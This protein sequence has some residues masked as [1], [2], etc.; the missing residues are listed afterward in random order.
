[1]MAD[2][3]RAGNFSSSNI[4]RLCTDGSRPMTPEEKQEFV[5]A[6]GDKRKKNTWDYGAS[7]YSY[8]KE[9]KREI[10][11][12]RQVDNESKANASDWGNM[13]EAI[14]HE[15]L[16]ISYQ[17]VNNDRYKHPDLPWTGAPDEIAGELLVGDI[18]S[19]FTLTSFLDVYEVLSYEDMA[20]ALKNVKPEWYWQLIS[21]SILTE[22]PWCELILFMP[23]KSMIKELIFEHSE[24]SGYWFHNKSEKSLPWTAEDSDIPALSRIPFIAPN[25]DIE[26]LT[27][28]V[29]AATKLLKEQ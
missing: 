23:K 8:V 11:A 18:K 3:D 5:D 15:M 10:L 6:G 4:Y 12:G 14:V 25:E 28:R 29:R 27:D 22:R 13:C 17:L 19:P 20:D 21:N 16:P 26:F 1:M 24:R 7:F 9:K 2:T